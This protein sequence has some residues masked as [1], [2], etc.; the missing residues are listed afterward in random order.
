VG[1]RYEGG[2]SWGGSVAS[3]ITDDGKLLKLVDDDDLGEEIE[4][5]EEEA[6]G[7]GFIPQLL[8]TPAKIVKKSTAVSGVGSM[9]LIGNDDTFLKS[10]NLDLDSLENN[11]F[12]ELR[13]L[14]AKED[15]YKDTE[16]M[17][18]FFSLLKFEN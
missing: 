13:Q 15:I 7:S 11:D 12:E 8:V 6:E 2:S 17:S 16:D 1:E 9:D 10:D 14:E 4:K 18:S 3:K 5:A